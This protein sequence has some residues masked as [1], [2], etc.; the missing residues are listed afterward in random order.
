MW[1]VECVITLAKNVND[2][3]DAITGTFTSL[4]V[5]IVSTSVVTHRIIRPN[6]PTLRTVT[7]RFNTG[8]VTT[9]KALRHQTL[10][11]QVFTG[12]RRGG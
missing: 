1:V 8:V 12:P 5:G 7:S 4:K 3:G 10:H 11:R 6:T 2:N 9:S